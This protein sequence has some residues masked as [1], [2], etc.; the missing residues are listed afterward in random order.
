M[1]W[2]FALV[3]AAAS[4]GSFHTL[5]PDHWVPFAALSRAERW[6]GGRTALITALCGFGH[7]TVSVGL[8]VLGVFFSLE[9]LQALGH[10]LESMA[11]VLLIGFG[12]VYGL[13]GLH[14][15]IRSGWHDHGDADA[16]PH[17]HAHVH[18]HWHGHHDPREGRVTPWTLFLLFSADPCVAVVPL[19][20]AAVPL[21]WSST[22]A[23]VIAYELATIATMLVLVLPA[24][25]LVGAVGG[26][27]AERFGDVLAGGTIAAVGLLVLGLGL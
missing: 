12:V 10:R 4:I 26:R 5:A 15:G 18:G 6:S 8:G 20:F 19:M 23:V 25:A 27:W 9:L 17:W 11:G 13:W 3:A 1:R 21:G 22:L 14:R 7:V 2:T 16:P 24:R